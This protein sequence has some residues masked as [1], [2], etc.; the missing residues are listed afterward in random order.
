MHKSLLLI[1]ALL[2]S[3]HVAEAQEIFDFEAKIENRDRF[4]F[5]EMNYSNKKDNINLS[6]TLILPKSDYE[7]IV[8]IVPGSGKDT[9]HSHFV[10][11]ETLLEN[12]IG[13]FRFDERG[14]GKSEGLISSGALKLSGDL[15]AGISYLKNQKELVDKKFGVIG[16]SLGGM[17]AIDAYEKQNQ[18]DFLVLWAA[19]VKKNSAF[20]KH[21]I[22]SENPF[23]GAITAET[24]Q[25][26]LEIVEIIHQQIIENEELNAWD[27]YKKCKKI[28]KDQLE[29]K[30]SQFQVYIM[31]YVVEIVRANY[32]QTYA[33]A[34][35]PVLY[36]IGTK[37]K[38]V[39]PRNSSDLIKEFDNSFIDFRLY[40][41]L[42]H[43]MT[44]G[45]LTGIAR[46]V[47]H[48]DDQVKNDVVEW[49]KNR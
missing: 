16:H 7:S 45:E 26:K 49:I 29:V 40:E 43:Y 20:V 18:L 17:A 32:E 1:F 46:E 41:G 15:S 42:N 27:I 5:K 21:Q 39:S 10:L 47:Y 48:L 36:I 22:E 24:K 4:I 3:F 33:T 34:D 11:A 12:N 9:R 14:V 28:L 19:P 30:K 35:V 6:G 2:F 23:F 37:D 13:V 25:K 38:F 31:P 8:T 44:I